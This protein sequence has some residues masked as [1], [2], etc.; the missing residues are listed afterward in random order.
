MKIT[1]IYEN[2][3]NKYGTEQKEISFVVGTGS[4]LLNRALIAG[5]YPSGRI[6]EIFGPE[7]A[8]KTTLGIHALASA[9]SMGLKV[10]LIDA[11]C[12][13]DEE[14]AK[15]VGLKGKKNVDFFYGTPDYGEQAFEI[16]FDLLVSGVS[17]IVI[18]SVAALTPKAEI[19]GEMGEAHM[20]LQARMM[21]Q[22]MR[23]LTKLVHDSNAVVIFMNQIR[24]KIGVFFGSPETT[25]G[26]R[27]LKFYASQRIEVRNGEALKIGNNVYGKFVKIK[28]VKN[29]VGP[30]LRICQI[31]FVFGRGIDLGR[32][33]FD[34]LVLHGKI[35][36]KS[37]YYYYGEEKLGNGSAKA[38]MIINEDLDRW[39]DILN[40]KS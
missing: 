32:E 17:L 6:I 33:I 21:S 28:V 4:Y 3:L 16:M 38:T 18:D 31:P 20:G 24:S 15:A 36:K 23:K 7:G 34:E 30:P 27:A 29:K 35:T 2:Y 25:T 37:S 40:D 10:A 13:L 22:G 12:A 26:G 39:R 1:E 9:Q 14:Y 11:E 19:E 5:G 8:G